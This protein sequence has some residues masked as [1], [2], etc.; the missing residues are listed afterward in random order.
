MTAGFRSTFGKTGG[1]RPPL[2]AAIGLKLPLGLKPEDS[3]IQDGRRSLESRDQ[4]RVSR[5]VC[6]GTCRRPASNRVA[7]EGVEQLEIRTDL[8]DLFQREFLPDAD[9][10]QL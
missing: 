5:V 7:V 3:R 6:G 2:H 4:S 10:H 9:I 1:H 8:S